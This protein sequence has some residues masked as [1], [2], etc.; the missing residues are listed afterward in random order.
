MVTRQAASSSQSIFH[1]L[2]DPTRRRLL[3]D[4]AAGPRPAGKL[5]GDFSSSRPAVARHLRVL[6]DAGLVR[7]RPHGR[8]RVYALDA[9]PLKSV[10]RWVARYEA[11]WNERPDEPGEHPA[12]PGRM[13]KRTRA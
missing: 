9:R 7:V 2:A 13:G 10:A 1:A 6:R 8:E 3:E 11:L 12:K 4:L 5:A